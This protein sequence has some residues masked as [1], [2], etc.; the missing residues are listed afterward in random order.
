VVEV[1][2]SFS[3]SRNYRSL[4]GTKA[5]LQSCVLPGAAA[6]RWPLTQDSKKVG[7]LTKRLDDGSI[8]G[9]GEWDEV[10]PGCSWSISVPGNAGYASS[11]EKCKPD[12]AGRWGSKRRLDFPMGRPL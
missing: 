5:L 7:V 3:G 9:G 10:N 11:C 2:T 12:A 1:R 8:V 6:L 4:K